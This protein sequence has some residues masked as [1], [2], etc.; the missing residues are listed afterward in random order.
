MFDAS[1]KY[2]AIVLIHGGPQG[3]WEDAWS[4][5]WNGE[6]FASRG[7]A[8]FMPNP[9]GS[10][11]YGQPFV[12]GVSRDWGG[13]AYV[14]IMNGV[15]RF[16][17]LPYVDADRVGAAGASYGGYMI[18]W[19]LGHTDRFKALVSHDGVYNLE[20]MAYTTEELWFTDWEFGGNPWDNPE[21]YAKWSP[22]RFVKNFKTPTLVV[23]GELDYRVPV[24]QGLE[25]FTA[26][27]RRG[28]PS[29][30][31]Y[32]ED[33]G[34]WVLKPQNSKLWYSTVLGWMDQWLKK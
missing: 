15:D 12:E 27:Q 16:V 19:I 24:N 17:A 9:R 5:R 20:S 26:L 18:D 10:T 29:K 4:Y 14:D 13:K 31:L 30:L 33:E 8:V 1:K 22:H 6:M 34:H 2:P 25:L 23:H 28:V 32:F 21:L 3:A 7:Y 11:G